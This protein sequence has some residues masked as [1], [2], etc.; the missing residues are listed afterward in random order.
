MTTTVASP[1]RTDPHLLMIQ[2]T[3]R[4][5]A[6][7]D[8]YAALTEL[9]EG[10][11]QTEQPLVNQPFS[12]YERSTVTAVKDSWTIGNN[13]PFIVQELLRIG[14]ASFSTDFLEAI[15]GWLRVTEDKHQELVKQLAQAIIDAYPTTLTIYFVRS[16]ASLPHQ[17]RHQLDKRL[18]AEHSS[19]LKPDML[20]AILQGLTNGHRQHA[21]IA[22][23]KAL[24][25]EFE[26][27]DLEP[28]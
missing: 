9:L 2:A 10:C 26:L 15:V 18:L 23:S 13:Q 6:E 11:R 27:M 4:N 5:A 14:P 21:I 22:M 12:S 17:F 16:W 1:T 28:A 3:N 8:R 24:L 19:S 25:A 7:A 20:K